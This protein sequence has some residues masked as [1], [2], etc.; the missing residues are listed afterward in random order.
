M[1]FRMTLGAFVCSLVLTGCG[2]PW[3]GQQGDATGSGRDAAFVGRWFIKQPDA[4]TYRLTIQASGDYTL[5]QNMMNTWEDQ[6]HGQWATSGSDI[7]FTDDQGNDSGTLRMTPECGFLVG[8]EKSNIWVHDGPVSTCPNP[9]APLSTV[10][11]CIAGLHHQHVD[12]GCGWPCPA[13]VD[14]YDLD[15]NEDRTFYY[16]HASLDDIT[17]T[18]EYG[19]GSWKVRGG[20]L[21]LDYIHASPT[22]TAISEDAGSHLCAGDT[23]YESV[24]DSSCA[25]LLGNHN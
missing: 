9:V 15:L 1:N 4:I 17:W 12:S 18:Y 24:L 16:E 14:D 8:R 19:W 13:R 21:E 2:A 20:T 3:N 7:S 25:A 22:S 5:A 23:C 6:E 11:A 10:E